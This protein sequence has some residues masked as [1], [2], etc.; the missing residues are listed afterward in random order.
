M[1]RV[2]GCAADTIFK[3]CQKEDVSLFIGAGTSI[4][5]PS[6]LPSAAA[7]KWQ[8][9]KLLAEVP[10]RLHDIEKDRDLMEEYLSAHALELFVQD[11]VEVFGTSA[12]D[13]YNVFKHGEPNL[14]HLLIAKMANHGLIKRVFTTNFDILI[15]KALA[16]ECVK[17][18]AIETEHDFAEYL[19][20]PENYPNFPVFKLHGTITFTGKGQETE[21]RTVEAI[22][23]LKFQTRLLA[24]HLKQYGIETVSVGFERSISP[25][26]TLIGSLARLGLNLSQFSRD[27][28]VSA[29][30]KSTFVVIGW[31]GFDLDISPL[32]LENKPKAIWI[33]HNTSSQKPKPK[34][35]N[36]EDEIKGIIKALQS[37]GLSQN[38]IDYALLA[39]GNLPLDVL[40]SAEVERNDI[41]NGGDGELFEVH[42]PDLIKRLWELFSPQIGPVPDIPDT[43][44]E[45]EMRVSD[46]LEAWSESV[47]S[48]LRNWFDAKFFLQHGEFQ[49]TKPELEDL[50]D[51]A[52]EQS[53]YEIEAL[54]LLDLADLYAMHGDR[55]DANRCYEEAC[56]LYENKI[57]GKHK[58]LSG[59]FKPLQL[60][61]IPERAYFGVGLLACDFFRFKEA[62]SAFSRMSTDKIIVDALVHFCREEF[63]KVHELLSRLKLRTKY[64]TKFHYYLYCYLRL[65]DADIFWLYK[66]H[67]AAEM[68]YLGA[69]SMATK[70]GW[71]RH[72]VH[73][74]NGL[75]KTYSMR[76]PKFN[77]MKAAKYA[78]QAI[79]VADM[80]Q[81]R[82]GR[83]FA[84]YYFGQIYGSIGMWDVAKGAVR[85][86][87]KYF[88][89]MGHDAGLKIIREHVPLAWNVNDDDVTHVEDGEDIKET[90]R[91]QKERLSGDKI[92]AE[93]MKIFND[94]TPFPGPWEPK[95]GKEH[96]Q[97]QVI[98]VISGMKAH[99]RQVGQLVKQSPGLKIAGGFEAENVEIVGKNICWLT[100][101]A[102]LPLSPMRFTVDID[103]PETYDELSG[104][105]RSIQSK[106]RP[107]E[108]LISSG[109]ITPCPTKIEEYDGIY[110]VS[111]SYDA[112][113]VNHFGDEVFWVSFSDKEISQSGS[114]ETEELAPE[115]VVDL[116]LPHV[117]RLPLS[118]ILRLRKELNGPLVRFQ[119][120]LVSF[121]RSSDIVASEDELFELFGRLDVAIEHLVKAFE[122]IEDQYQLATL[123]MTY[124]FGV[125]SLVPTVPSGSV[126]NFIALWQSSEP[127]RTLRHIRLVHPKQRELKDP[128]FRLYFWVDTLSR[129]LGWTS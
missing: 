128:P 48:R 105:I 108:S 103:D 79:S 117:S 73:A 9:S 27:V 18:H 96:E 11:L 46:T 90:L 51:S 41:V 121:I 13:V 97:K 66:N 29:L 16:K 93:F 104:K 125:V 126:K 77:M 95:A 61:E 54:V 124:K 83:A 4:D 119:G 8:I 80:A 56:E 15:E 68:Q 31:N 55:E 42:T 63:E 118:E 20:N 116:F 32:F 86:A 85:F 2:V 94:V 34:L 91:S 3:L 69:L 5:S 92:G 45:V 87:K 122:S 40:P 67:R 50:V 110:N 23:D 78:A 43:R 109:V 1:K 28:L 70:I 25:K 22:S 102:I 19:V 21:N 64:P 84:N 111:R 72:V 38:S 129:E 98:G 37:K 89:E 101:V 60:S 114:S 39:T 10:P 26:D 47:N 127:L 36:T 53:F 52:R 14:Y 49:N 76:G 6:N 115:H 74:L 100:S 35:S 30:K 7:L 107:F 33:G 17:Y 71:P 120:E 58:N 113:Q 57:H 75:V 24:K 123:G 99:A 62:E 12:Y 65:I 59:W 112:F 106:L 82:V 88:T 44:A 81:Y